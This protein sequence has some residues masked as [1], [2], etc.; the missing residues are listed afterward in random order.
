MP[1]QD[2]TAQ[3]AK[4]NYERKVGDQQYVRRMQEA[5]IMERERATAEGRY[6]RQQQSS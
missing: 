5:W 4:D 6:K 3:Q 2:F 1:D